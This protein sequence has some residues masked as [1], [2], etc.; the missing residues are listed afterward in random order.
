[1]CDLLGGSPFLTCTKIVRDYWD[2]TEL[3][4]GVNL[5]MLLEIMSGINNLSISDL[6]NIALNAGKEGVTDIK[7]RLGKK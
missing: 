3:V 4:T 1:M 2:Q 6:K 7:E 5:G